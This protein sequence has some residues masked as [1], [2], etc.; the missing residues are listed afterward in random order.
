MPKHKVDNLGDLQKYV[1]LRGVITAIDSDNDTATI[2][3]GGSQYSDALIYYHC[4]P[5]AAKRENGAITGGASGF[6]EQDEVIVMARIESAGGGYSKLWVVGHTDGVKKCSAKYG[7]VT[8]NGYDLVQT[9]NSQIFVLKIQDTDGK[10]GLIACDRSGR[11]RFPDD[12]SS[13]SKLSLWYVGGYANIF[14]GWYFENLN[15]WTVT[16]GTATVN[17][18]GTCTIP[19]STSLYQQNTYTAT[20]MRFNYIY[21]QALVV[22]EISG[23]L[24]VVTPSGSL[25]ITEPGP[26]AIPVCRVQYGNTGAAASYFYCITGENSTAKIS[27][28]M[29]WFSGKQWNFSSSFTRVVDQL[30]DDQ[31]HVDSTPGAVG[32]YDVPNYYGYTVDLFQYY[33]EVPAGGYDVG[34]GILRYSKTT[35]PFNFQV[36][37]ANGS[38]TGQEDW[39][40][41]LKRCRQIL[42]NTEINKLSIGTIDFYGQNNVP[43]RLVPMPVMAI[44]QKRTYHTYGYACFCQNGVS[45]NC[46][47]EHVA[48]AKG[49]VIPTRNFGSYSSIPSSWYCSGVHWAASTVPLGPPAVY[50]VNLFSA[51]DETI[52]KYSGAILVTDDNGSNPSFTDASAH[53]GYDQTQFLACSDDWAAEHEGEPAPEYPSQHISDFDVYEWEMISANGPSDRLPM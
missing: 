7:K 42:L 12:F 46:S 6:A 25:V 43:A 24:T 20:Y 22:N 15:D 34:A 53:M 27:I 1:Y 17:G 32:D 5:D 2:T 51:N 4:G 18:D 44:Q 49:G 19:P 3:I 41:S 13:K 23:T 11:F 36:I 30:F 50:W 31:G 8:F 38:L 26:Y 16:G 45:F 14:H 39:V 21:I 29:Q 47:D 28:P 33:I 10:V 37:Y 48:F 35:Y 9:G 40:I 52:G